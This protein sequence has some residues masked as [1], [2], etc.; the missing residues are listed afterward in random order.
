[1]HLI[2]SKHLNHLSYFKSG[3]ISILL[4]VQSKIDLILCFHIKT[5]RCS[6]VPGTQSSL[7]DVVVCTVTAVLIVAAGFDKNHHFIPSTFPPLHFY[8]LGCNSSLLVSLFMMFFYFTPRDLY[9]HTKT[10]CSIQLYQLVE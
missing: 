4:N 7:C 9:V 3:S 2:N 6:F 10:S 5:Q 1:M 8:L